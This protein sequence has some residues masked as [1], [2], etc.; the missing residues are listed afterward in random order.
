MGAVY[1]PAVNRVSILVAW[2][3]LSLFSLIGCSGSDSSS[4][5]AR[6]GA[7]AAKASPR[8]S[9]PVQTGYARRTVKDCSFL[10]GRPD[11]LAAVSAADIRPSVRRMPTLNHLGCDW[12]R[13]N[14][15]A[16][17]LVVDVWVYASASE[18]READIARA[19]RA[20]RRAHESAPCLPPVE[21]AL[22]PEGSGWEEA[23]LKVFEHE[24]MMF[25]VRRGNVLVSVGYH[26]DI[27]P[28]RRQERAC[29]QIAQ[30]VLEAIEWE[31]DGVRV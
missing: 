28:D 17:P 4:G 9:A 16:V 2:L 27:T 26:G 20:H 15:S 5:E 13:D 18:S 6:A 22:R 29:L 14:P 25:D 3:A 31:S 19:R 21:G 24:G 10:D 30:L 11:L 7:S 12:K 1:A 23:C 8:S